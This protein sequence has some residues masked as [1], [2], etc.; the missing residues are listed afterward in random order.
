MKSRFSS[1]FYLYLSSPVLLSH[2]SACG[3]IQL[4][5]IPQSS[6]LPLVWLLP[7]VILL[8]RSEMRATDVS[9]H[10]RTF[11]ICYFTCP[12]KTYFL[13]H[14]KEDLI[15]IIVCRYVSPLLRDPAVVRKLYYAV[16]YPLLKNFI[17]SSLSYFMEIRTWGYLQSLML[18]LYISFIPTATPPS[19]H[20]NLPSAYYV[21]TFLFSLMWERIFSITGNIYPDF[22][23]RLTGSWLQKAYVKHHLAC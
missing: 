18:S 15:C 4:R 3:S 20:S 11:V 21:C 1:I 6:L 8:L 16:W 17:K 23:N 9:Q 13:T 5:F 7:A 2:C 19:T 22:P 10:P 14:S 12:G